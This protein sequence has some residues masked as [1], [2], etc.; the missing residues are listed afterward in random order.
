M[1]DI[2]DAV[3]GLRNLS[4]GDEEQ[5]RIGDDLD[6]VEPAELRQQVRELIDSGDYDNAYAAAIRPVLETLTRDAVAD[7]V[8][9]WVVEFLSDDQGDVATEQL[10][11]AI[12][13]FRDCMQMYDQLVADEWWVENPYAGARP[14]ASN[15]K[16]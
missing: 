3:Y 2:N 16:A 9:A 15:E 10:D 12:A 5:V 8:H 11:N 1:F 4:V 14:S 13:L 7:A 6:N